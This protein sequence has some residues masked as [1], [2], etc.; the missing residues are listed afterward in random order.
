MKFHWVWSLFNISKLR[1][2]ALWL[3]ISQLDRKN[4][5]TDSFKYVFSPD[6]PKT[7][8]L[9]FSPQKALVFTLHSSIRQETVAVEA[10]K[11]EFRGV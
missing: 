3:K 7:K 9:S 2:N 6:K 8:G 1:I 4:Y 5:V 11:D 10:E